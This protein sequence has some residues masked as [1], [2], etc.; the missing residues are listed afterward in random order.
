MDQE[1]FGH[2]EQ[3]LASVEKRIQIFFVVLTLYNKV[4]TIVNEE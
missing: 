3:T 1:L 4:S 2:L